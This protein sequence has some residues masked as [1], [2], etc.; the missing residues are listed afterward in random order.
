MSPTT[1]PWLG[2]IRR[3]AVLGVLGALVLGVGDR[4]APEAP[5]LPELEV[6]V[7][8]DRTTSMSALDDPAGSRITAVRRD[9]TA[10]GE[11]LESAR[12]TLVTVGASAQVV[13]PATADRVAYADAVGALQVEA[14]DAGSGSAAARFVP[15][16]ARLLDRFDPASGR[17]P[18]LVYAGDG[19]D[20]T[21]GDV[22][23]LLE[24]RGRFAA[25]TVLGYGTTSG[26]VMPLAR[27]A[28]DAEP[29][30]PTDAGDLVPDVATGLPAIS[31]AHPNTLT[32]IAEQVSGRYLRCDGTQDMGD[33][34]ARLQRAAYSD[35]GPVGA[36][37][38]LGWFW[39]LLLLLL[40][41]P[42]LRTGWRQWLEAR[43]EVG[44]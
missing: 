3:L 23:S 28:V 18:V 44:S 39:G 33:V 30:H 26:G 34:A 9:L 6:L 24:L 20:T 22:S 1:W 14:P 40:A 7:V 8:V 4:D 15:V 36:A 43:R 41:L 19:E 32:G 16:V 42:D 21:D 31:R 25:A 10:L 12:F 35:L 5:P 27:V 11:E 38:Q 37:R 29:P 17:L 2:A 13:L